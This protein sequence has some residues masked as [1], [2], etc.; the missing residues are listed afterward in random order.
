MEKL[1]IDGK[2]RLMT[3]QKVV[4]DS[5][6]R[7]GCSHLK[8]VLQRVEMMT[9]LALINLPH[10][11]FYQATLDKFTPPLTPSAARRPKFVPPVIM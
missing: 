8:F 2:S 7:I 3:K 6:R 5:V 4:N 9:N 10:Q 1:L 11:I